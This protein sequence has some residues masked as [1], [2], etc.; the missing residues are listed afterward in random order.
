MLNTVNKFRRNVSNLKVRSFSSQLL[1]Y[2]N[3]YLDKDETRVKIRSDELE[4]KWK[5]VTLLVKLTKTGIL[6]QLVNSTESITGKYVKCKTGFYVVISN[7]E[8]NVCAT[9]TSTSYDMNVKTIFKYFD[10]QGV[11]QFRRTSVE[12]SNYIKD[13]ETWKITPK[14]PDI[15][16]N[17]TEHCYQWRIENDHV[18]QR[19]VRNY[20]YPDGTKAFIDI[21]NSDNCYI[22]Y[23]KIDSLVK[24]IPDYGNYYGIDN[25]VFFKYFQ[26]EA[27]LGDIIDNFHS[28]GHVIRNGIQ[29]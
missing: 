6:Y 21:K 5:S 17:Y 7:K 1:N 9:E 25:E 8:S 26:S 4:L 18:L 28:K 24:E 19:R 13:A 3:I 16:E 2:L 29:I 20:L 15:M 14:E 27:T 12:V 23:K 22:R 11:E 10:K